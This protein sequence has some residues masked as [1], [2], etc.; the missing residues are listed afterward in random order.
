MA[1]ANDGG[2]DFIKEGNIYQYKEEG[3][4]AMV[5]VLKDRSDKDTYEFDLEVVASADQ[6]FSPGL[7][8]NVSHTKN[9]GGFW[10]EMLQFYEGVEYIPLPIGKPWP[11]A[12]LGHEFEGLK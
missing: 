7:K 4:V 2:W 3:C 10:N 11:F 8:F 6:S 5:R 12:L 1:R 9:P